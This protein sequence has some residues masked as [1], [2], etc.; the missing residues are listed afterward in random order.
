MKKS[1][2]ITRNLNINANNNIIAFKSDNV[3]YVEIR[4]GAVQYKNENNEDVE[5]KGLVI[6]VNTTI[7]NPEPTT[8]FTATQDKALTFLQ[9]N[10]GDFLKFSKIKGREENEAIWINKDNIVKT[11]IIKNQNKGI[12]YLDENNFLHPIVSLEDFEE[13]NKEK[14]LLQKLNEKAVLENNEKLDKERVEEEKVVNDN[15][16]VNTTNTTISENVESLEE[17]QNKSKN[18]VSTQFSLRPL[19]RE[20]AI[21]ENKEIVELKDYTL[22]LYFKSHDNSLLQIQRQV[23]FDHTIEGQEEY[24]MYDIMIDYLESI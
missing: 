7:V 15:E 22:L 16:D 2:L 3:N 9:Q 4:N 6:N 11:E 20:M 8:Y 23:E 5:L 24:N 18:E 13:F 10:L 19:T 1:V 17:E 12:F 21:N 14:N